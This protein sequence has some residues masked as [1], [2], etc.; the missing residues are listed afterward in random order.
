LFFSGTN[1]ENAMVF[2]SGDH[3]ASASFSVAW[4]T[5]VGGPSASIQRMKICVPRGSPSAK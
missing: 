2:P 5:C 1:M 3:R 4:V